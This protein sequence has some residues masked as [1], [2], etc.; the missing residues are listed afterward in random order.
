MLSDQHHALFVYL[1]LLLSSDDILW[2]RENLVGNHLCHNLLDQLQF[3]EFIIFSSVI[4]YWLIKTKSFL[5]SIITLWSFICTLEEN[6]MC[7]LL[8]LHYFQTIKQKLYFLPESSDQFNNLNVYF[9]FL[10]FFL[11]RFY[12]S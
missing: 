5:P 8:Y 6:F 1:N 10:L 7:V 4:F 3:F 9:V 12:S 11:I 2:S